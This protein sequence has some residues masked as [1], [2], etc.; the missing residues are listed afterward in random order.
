MG[1]SSDA[2]LRGS[3]RIVFPARRNRDLIKS[4]RS[5]RHVAV[6]ATPTSDAFASNSDP[7]KSALIRVKKFF[8]MQKTSF[9]DLRAKNHHRPRRTGPQRTPRFRHGL[10]RANPRRS[11]SKKL[12]QKP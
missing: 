3:T 2:D 8:H 4:G 6:I 9:K 7:R 5:Q 10:I 1:A 11:A 12:P